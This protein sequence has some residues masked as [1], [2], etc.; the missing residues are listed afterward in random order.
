MDLHTRF[1]FGKRIG[2]TIVEITADEKHAWIY[3]REEEDHVDGGRS[4]YLKPQE[5]DLFISA[6]TLYK[7][8]ILNQKRRSYADDSTQ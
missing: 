8:R 4:I 7:H 1:T 3:V 5:I 6:L 2:S